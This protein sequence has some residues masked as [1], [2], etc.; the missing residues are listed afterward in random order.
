MPSIISVCWA[1]CARG[2][3]NSGTAF[4]MAST[5]VSAEQ[6]EANALS[7]SSRPT[8]STV[9]G[10]WPTGGTSGWERSRPLTM[11]M[12]MA[13]MNRIVGTMNT[14]ADSAT[15][16]QVD[17]GDQRQHG[18]AQPYPGAVQGREG[19]R[20]RGHPGRDADGGV[21]H[22]VDGERGGRDQAGRA[23]QVPLGHRVGAA[24]ARERGDD[25]PV[26]DDQHDQQHHDGQRDRQRVVQPD[27]ARRGQHDDDGLGT[28]GDGG[29]RVEGEGG[30]A[31][32]RGQPVRF[33][34]VLRF[35]RV[36]HSVADRHVCSSCPV[37]Q[38]R[39]PRPSRLGNYPAGRGDQLA[40]HRHLPE[41]CGLG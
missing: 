4:A 14:R 1:R 37:A 24:A 10:R 23:A 29:E 2:R 19:G 11:T 6:P 34:G 9:E 5:P 3:L 36:R 17:P 13:R 32:Q 15:P 25:L 20:Q 35:R 27:G 33:L 16:D 40:D 18:Q 38:R 8:A 26:G 30:Q 41:N 21:Q 12:A 22:V 28:V 39:A 7:S 31:L